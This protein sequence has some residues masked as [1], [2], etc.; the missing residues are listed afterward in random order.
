MSS[1]LNAF[2]D[3]DCETEVETLRENYREIFFGEVP[4]CESAVRPETYLIV[5]RRGSGKTALSHY[6]GFRNPR[7]PVHLIDV[8]EPRA[9]TAV[10]SNT[11]ISGTD[12]RQVAIT[13]LVRVWEHVIWRIIFRS[14]AS[15]N[16]R[17]SA[18]CSDLCVPERRN[19]MEKLLKAVLSFLADKQPGDIDDKLEDLSPDLAN[20]AKQI[21]I[22]YASHTPIVV[23]MDTLEQYDLSKTALMN[24]LAALVQYG[25]MFNTRHREQGIHLKVFMAGEVFP[26]LKEE[27]ILNTLKSVRNPVYLA[28]RPRDLLR[29]ICW[30]F[31]KHL[32]E[33]GE[34]LEE[35]KRPIDWDNPDAVHRRMWVPYFGAS[36]VNGKGMP[37]NSFA[38]V[39]RHTQMRPRQLIK[40][41]N[42]ISARSSQFPRFENDE[43][44]SAIAE[45]E[46]DLATEIIN[47]YSGMYPGVGRIVAALDGL[48]MVFT[49][50]E[51]DKRAKESASHWNNGNYSPASFRRLMAELGVVGR[52]VRENPNAGFIDAEFEYS[53]TDRL[54]LSYRDKCVIHPMFYRKLKVDTGS[55]VRIMPFSTIRERVEAEGD[56]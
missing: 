44:V 9:F 2:G 13:R 16:A 53:L 24:S 51:L 3:A 19:I 1:R 36:V 40:L 15:E 10:L 43:I 35:S 30:R 49:G 6:F 27:V 4:F 46:S 34:L 17:L 22:D 18:I 25:A 12:D 54:P 45:S 32:K 38:Y 26:Y 5:G 55:Q 39:L 42:D 37:E 41:C 23:A 47:S 56:F 7:K 52:V 33:S 28:W 20:E 21:V 50:N 11:E 29:L 48:P 31:Y 8:D 14:I